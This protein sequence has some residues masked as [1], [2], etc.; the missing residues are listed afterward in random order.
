MVDI[1]TYKNRNFRQSP[2]K[3]AR[4]APM[5]KHYSP[6]RGFHLFGKDVFRLERTDEIEREVGLQRKKSKE[7]VVD[8]I[9]QHE[10]VA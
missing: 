10:Q 9:K 3:M 6:S 5:P 8:A 4:R 7:R 2:Q 1:A